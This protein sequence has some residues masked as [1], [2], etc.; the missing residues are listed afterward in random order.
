MNVGRRLK[1]IKTQD[2]EL[3]LVHRLRRWTNA[4]PTFNKRLV[5]AGIYVYAVGLYHARLRRWPNSKPTALVC[6]DVVYVAGYA[7][8]LIQIKQ[9]KTNSRQ[10]NCSFFK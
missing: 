1:Y 2:V 5:S 6:W 3:M 7:N 8:I 9:N 4:K 10:K